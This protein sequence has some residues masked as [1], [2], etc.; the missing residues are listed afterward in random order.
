MLFKKCQHVVTDG[1]HLSYRY[2]DRDKLKLFPEATAE[3]PA[4][5]PKTKNYWSSLPFF[6]PSRPGWTVSPHQAQRSGVS[7]D[8]AGRSR[9]PA[10]SSP[11]SLPDPQVGSQSQTQSLPPGQA[12]GLLPTCVLHRGLKRKSCI[13]ELPVKGVSHKVALRCV[14][15]REGPV[16]WRGPAQRPIQYWGE[17]GGCLQTSS[18][19]MPQ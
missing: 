9:Q 16:T 5:L 10:V 4:E 12:G 19:L 8:L 2:L 17:G 11:D 18:K 6:F 7:L 14:G 13:F 15:C 1:V 3:V